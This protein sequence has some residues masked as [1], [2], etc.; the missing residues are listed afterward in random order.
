MFAIHAQS[1]YQSHFRNGVFFARNI[2]AATLDE[3]AAAPFDAAARR[4]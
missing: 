2:G 3:K 1:S 4:V